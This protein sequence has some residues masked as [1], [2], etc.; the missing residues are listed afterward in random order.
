MEQLKGQTPAEQALL[1]AGLLRGCTR[2][3]PGFFRGPAGGE[4]REP[5]APFSEGDGVALSE[6]A[7]IELTTAHFET[8]IYERAVGAAL[9]DMPPGPLL[10]LG[11]GDGRI[12]R[13]LLARWQGPVLA[14]DC[15]Q[16]ALAR[17]HAA[18]SQEERQRIV[19]LCCGIKELPLPAASV[20]G[21]VAIETLYYLGREFEAALQVLARSLRPGGRLVHAEPTLEGWLLYC[22]AVDDWAGALATAGEGAV[23]TRYR[24]FTPEQMRSLHAACGLRPVAQDQTPL[25][26]ILLVNRL[27]RSG[28]PEAQRLEILRAVRAAAEQCPTPRCVIY[29]AAPTADEEL[30]A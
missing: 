24:G 5:L 14:C 21:I 20:S 26:N 30:D 3:A 13:M 11:A 15:N 9:A 22:V 12:T 29:T 4:C 27:A 6:R 10:E 16:A 19:L 28:L 7:K 2:L 17:L 1:E 25:V 18:L 8:P 23:E